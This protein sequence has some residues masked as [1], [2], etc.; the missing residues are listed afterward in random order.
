MKE[1]IFNSAEI[2]HQAPAS[3]FVRHD[4]WR[5]W[6]VGLLILFVGLC[7]DHTLVWGHSDLDPRQSIPKKWEQ[8]MLNVPSETEAPTVE[9]RLQVPAAFEIEVIEHNRIWKI[10]T[11]RDARGLIR[12][13]IWSGSQIPPQRFEVFKFLARNPTNPGIYRWR[14][15]QHYQAGEAGQW[16]AQTQ[17]VELD[18]MGGRRAESAWRSAQLATMVSFIAI[19][20]AI[21]LIIFTVIN[22]MQYGRR[23]AE[24]GER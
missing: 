22:I 23:A 24:D 6:L 17:I 20:I 14:I 10:D 21:V 19:G 11:K 7:A 16:E 18:Q 5:W 2:H 8:Y 13:V 12:E 15:E 4:G 3:P 1:N 9:I